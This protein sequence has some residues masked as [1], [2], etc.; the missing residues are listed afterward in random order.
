MPND[1]FGQGH[2]GLIIGPDFTTKVLPTIH[3]AA[4]VNAKIH[5][6]GV[7]LQSAQTAFYNNATLEEKLFH[8]V[9][10]LRDTIID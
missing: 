1:V 4:L 8:V 2:A 9:P 10:G 3:Q 6:D 7:G 5:Y